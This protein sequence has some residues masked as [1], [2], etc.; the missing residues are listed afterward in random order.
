MSCVLNSMSDGACTYF[1]QSTQGENL[2][3]RA[4]S[5]SAIPGFEEHPSSVYARKYLD[6]LEENGVRHL[7]K[8]LVIDRGTLHSLHIDAEFLP[9]DSEMEDKVLRILIQLCE[10]ML[11]PLFKLYSPSENDCLQLWTSIFGIIADRVSLHTGEKVLAASKVMRQMQTGEYSD[12]S[13]TGLKVDGLFRYND[14]ELSNI[15]LKSPEIGSRDLA[16]Q[17]RKNVRLACCLQEA[18][19]A[20]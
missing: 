19:A 16:I 18:H 7:R 17:N 13:D 2:V 9:P 10:F 12:V 15:E 5:T 11:D 1:E 20:V 4:R 3:G 8:E 14:I 6:T